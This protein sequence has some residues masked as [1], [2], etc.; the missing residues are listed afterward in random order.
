MEPIISKLQEGVKYPRFE[1]DATR[2]INDLVTHVTKERGIY[3]SNIEP[4]PNEHSIW[5]NT[6]DKKVYTYIDEK[7]TVIS[8]DRSFNINSD[9]NDVLPYPTINILYDQSIIYDRCESN[10]NYVIITSSNN[11]SKFIYNIIAD[12]DYTILNGNDIVSGTFMIHICN[13]YVYYIKISDNNIS[14]NLEFYA[15]AAQILIYYDGLDYEQ[16]ISGDFNKGDIQKLMEDIVLEQEE[17]ISDNLFTQTSIEPMD[18]STIV[19]GA[20]MPDRLSLAGEDVNDVT[21]YLFNNKLNFEDYDNIYNGFQYYNLT[22]FAN[23]MHIGDI[24]IDTS[25]GEY[26]DNSNIS[27]MNCIVGNNNKLI[28]EC[29]IENITEELSLFIINMNDN[30]KSSVHLKTNGHVTIYDYVNLCKTPFTSDGD[31]FNV[32]LENIYITTTM[33]DFSNPS[34]V[35]NFIDGNGDVIIDSELDIDS[36]QSNVVE[37]LNNTTV[38][39][40]TQNA[41]EFLYRTYNITADTAENHTIRYD[42][43]IH[44]EY[45]KLNGEVIYEKNVYYS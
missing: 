25:N 44:I 40:T 21:I 37:Q 39:T 41:N 19:L 30:D 38:Y 35:M 8:G 4:N 13:R 31:G 17:E 36:I 12:E 20:N 34:F 24:T 9:S 11:I 29:P 45:R 42:D 22:I 18:G 5:F 2:I 3:S 33:R 15:S 16:E 27:Q 1:R 28:I 43:H 26:I 7:W 32:L 14:E 23:C 10:G 6:N